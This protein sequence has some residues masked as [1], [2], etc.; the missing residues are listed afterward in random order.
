MT[1]PPS[2]ADEVRAMSTQASKRK[3]RQAKM[4]AVDL[5]D[6]NIRPDAWFVYVMPT[7]VGVEM[8]GSGRYGYWGD[9]PKVETD[10]DYI[11]V[12]G[13]DDEPTFVAS[14]TAIVTVHLAKGKHIEAVPFPVVKVEG[15][16]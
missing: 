8:I 15:Q 7:Q 5:E 6:S 11:V 3:P 13:D 1:H 14:K 12:S 2:R 16:E 4:T 10:D 9:K